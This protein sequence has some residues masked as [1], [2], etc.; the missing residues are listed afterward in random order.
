MGR[1]FFDLLRERSKEVNSL[2]CV[3][4]DPRYAL[5]PDADPAESVTKIIDENKRLIEATEKNTLCYKPN[6]AFYEALGVP[7][8]QALQVTLEFIPDEVPVILDAK[9]GDIGNTAL[10]YAKTVFEQFDVNAVTV[11]PYMGYDSIEP[12]LKYDER[13]VFVLCKTSNPGSE[14]FQMLVDKKSGDV[15]YMKVANTVAKWADSIGLVVGATDP[16]ALKNV[17]S[18][19]KDIWILAPGIGAQ[20]GT[21]KDAMEA[22]KDDDGYGIIPVVSRDIAHDSNPGEKARWYKDEINKYRN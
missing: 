14:D 22:G 21:V 17:R 7:G 6:I 2:L 3:G 5:S 16:E 20:G 18:A 10:A 13:G 4:L 19:H 8:L 9:R 11:S 1:L 15:M 12:F